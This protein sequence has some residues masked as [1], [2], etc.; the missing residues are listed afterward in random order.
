[1]VAAEAQELTGILLHCRHSARLR[2]PVGFARSAE[3]G[4]MQL[5]LV[6]NGWG[7]RLAGE[8]CETAWNKQRV[9]AVV[10]TGFCG[11]LDPGLAVG[12]IFCATRVEDADGTGSVEARSPGCSR[13]YLS[14]LL[15]SIDHV[16]QTA[17]EKRELRERG[18][19]A[20]EMEA[21]AVGLRAR[22]WGVPFYCPRVVT[23]VAGE[24]LKLDFNAARNGD[25]RL[26][27]ARLLWAAAR[28]PSPLVS[29]LIKLYHRSHL[30]VRA[31]GEFFADCRF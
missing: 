12:D 29:E 25:G 3:L 6:A 24:D 14:G 18:G 21:L 17:G 13:R 23:D 4:G 15:V 28:R 10:S 8:A 22:Q 20:V 5:F 16:A 11:A 2:W 7:G 26:S 9:D 30:A 19:S 1:M 31:L 27:V